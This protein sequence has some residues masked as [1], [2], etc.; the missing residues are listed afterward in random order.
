MSTTTDT[1][2]S[3]EQVLDGM[4]FAMVTTTSPHGLRARPL[5][6]LEQEDAV[7]R[8]LVSRD[9]QWV[10]ELAQPMASVQVAFADPGKNTYVALQGHAVLDDDPEL[11]ARLWNPAA[12]SFFDGPEDPDATVLECTI[13]DG[14]WWDAPGTAVGLAIAFVKQRLTGERPGES[15]RVEP[16]A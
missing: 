4:R 10:Q 6:L 12:E 5:T 7:L 3:L 1:V 11:I 14:E 9:S 2:R 16:E 13:F 8:F 15:G